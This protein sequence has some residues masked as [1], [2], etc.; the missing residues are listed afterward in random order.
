MKILLNNY[1]LEKKKLEG[2][3][4]ERE[5]EAEEILIKQRFLEQEN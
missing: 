1:L 2:L 3:L 5:G 4:E